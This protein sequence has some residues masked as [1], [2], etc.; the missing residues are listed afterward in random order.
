[1]GVSGAESR[2]SYEAHRSSSGRGIANMPVVAGC[3]R[4]AS[5]W[6]FLVP[7][8]VPSAGFEPTLDGF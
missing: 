8:V 6:G 4:G 3:A 7:S 2:S 1:V 5:N